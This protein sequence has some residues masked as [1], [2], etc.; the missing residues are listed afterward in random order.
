MSAFAI[1]IL[2]VYVMTPKPTVVYKYPSPFNV[3]TAVYKD[4]SGECYKFKAI[5]VDCSSVS[6]KLVLPQ[7]VQK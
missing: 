1:G 6:P 7:P 5:K 4:L 3:D 2:Y